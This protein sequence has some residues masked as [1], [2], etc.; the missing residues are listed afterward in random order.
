[1]ITTSKMVFVVPLR[2]S[3]QKSLNRPGQK[4][5]ITDRMMPWLIRVAAGSRRPVSSCGSCRPVRDSWGRG[6]VLPLRD[7]SISHSAT[8]RRSEIKVTGGQAGTVRYLE[9]T[10]FCGQIVR[11]L[12]LTLLG[13]AYNGP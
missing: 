7:L 5:R 13:V 9:L 11:P 8:P 1:M 6:T 3:R 4:L 10:K 12:S 2:Q